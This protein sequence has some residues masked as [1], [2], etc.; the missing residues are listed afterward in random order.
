MVYCVTV[1]IYPD[2]VLGVRLEVPA[3]KNRQCQFL[4]GIRI[5][6]TV[7]HVQS[8]KGALLE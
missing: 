7:I 4:V 6:F 8:K 3:Y 2:K 5:Y 1:G